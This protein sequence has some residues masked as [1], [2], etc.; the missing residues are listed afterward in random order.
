MIALIIAARDYQAA[1]DRAVALVKDEVRAARGGQQTIDQAIEN[2]L[3]S[4]DHRTLLGDPTGSASTIA[5]EANH[6]LRHAADNETRAR[7]MAASRRAI[8][9]LPKAPKSLKRNKAFRLDASGVAHAIDLA[10][11][12]SD[13]DDS[14]A[15]ELTDAKTVAELAKAQPLAADA[16]ENID[17][18]IAEDP[19]AAAWIASTMSGQGQDGEAEPQKLVDNSDTKPK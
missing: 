8:G 19:E 1:F 3:L 6:F 11:D 10:H 18:T 14:L 17:K 4:V 2:I 15:T 5:V 12:P 13:R 7:Q 9:I 16:R